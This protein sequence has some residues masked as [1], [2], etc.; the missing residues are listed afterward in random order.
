MEFWWYPLVRCVWPDPFRGE[1]DLSDL[2]RSL[3]RRPLHTWGILAPFVQARLRDASRDQLVEFFRELIELFEEQ[4][5]RIPWAQVCSW[6][7]LQHMEELFLQT[8]ECLPLEYIEQ[9]RH[10][11]G[12][13]ADPRWVEVEG[14]W[15]WRKVLHWARVALASVLEVFWSGMRSLDPN[16]SFASWWDR[17]LILS[18]LVRY[19]MLPVGLAALLSPLVASAWIVYA[20]AVAALVGL[21]Y[22]FRLPP[23]P[24]ERLIYSDHLT[25]LVAR[26][27]EPPPHVSEKDL[28]VLRAHAVARKPLLIVGKSGIGK[29]TLVEALVAHIAHSELGLREPDRTTCFRVRCADLVAS[30]RIGMTEVVQF[31]NE[32]I[33]PHRRNMM[34][35]FEEIDPFLSDAAALHLFKTQIV[36]CYQAAH[37]ALADAHAVPILVT[38]TEKEYAKLKA[39]DEDGSLRNRVAV[40]RLTPPESVEERSAILKHR[41]SKK[42]PSFEVDSDAMS[43]LLGQDLG[44]EVDDEN[45]STMSFYF[46]VIE[47]AILLHSVR[48]SQKYRLPRQDENEK[49]AQKISLFNCLVHGAHHHKRVSRRVRQLGGKLFLRAA[50]GAERKEYCLYQTLVV[51]ALHKMLNQKKEEGRQRA[52]CYLSSEDLKRSMEA[53]RGEFE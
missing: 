40:H 10:E 21:V 49:H 45:A 12:A 17:S 44:Q 28:E 50:S 15:G 46:R 13:L 29:S 4:C 22:L 42:Y 20:I 26:S 25:A 37:D 43:W 38:M 16:Q 6:F 47:H 5:D 1:E 19:V 52:V 18:V 9:Q 24:L 7:S 41:I 51:P 27:E 53:V 48:Y 30:R 3:Q 8:H 36:E 39:I 2:A 31:L 11:I 14:T 34:L 35:V 23:P 32:R 33:T